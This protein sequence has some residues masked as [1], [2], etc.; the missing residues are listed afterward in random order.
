MDDASMVGI[1]KFTVFGSWKMKKLFLT[2]G[3]LVLASTLACADTII[4]YST[5][6]VFT[7][8]GT[9]VGSYGAGADTA[10]LSFAGIPIGTT[11]SAPSNVSLGDI[12]ASATGTG[13]SIAD[14][15]TLYIYQTTPSVDNGIL[16]AT[17]TGT[18]TTNTS[19]GQIIFS[20]PG[21]VTLGDITYTVDG[22]VL[23]NGIRQLI[24]SPT[25]NGGLTSIQADTTVPEPGSLALLGTGL[26]GLGGLIRRKIN[27]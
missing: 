6:G 5:V 10:T 20:F 16:A 1:E 17:L 8:S 19:T 15:F 4:T 7:S 12:V 24:V 11:A 23:A 27:R 18:V 25:T 21:A 13:A 26:F 22:R 9:A 14:T 3:L 2:V